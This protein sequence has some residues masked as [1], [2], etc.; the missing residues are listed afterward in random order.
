[1]KMSGTTSIFLLNY[2]AVV[3]KMLVYIFSLLQQREEELQQEIYH[4]NYS[5]S[6]EQHEEH[7]WVL[8]EQISITCWQY[9]HSRRSG[10]SFQ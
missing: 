8:R 9:L 7:K 2:L 3:M 10:Q 5:E 6:G 4:E 1:M